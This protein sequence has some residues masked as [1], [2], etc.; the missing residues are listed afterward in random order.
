MH[1]LSVGNIKLPDIY[2]CEDKHEAKEAKHHGLPYVLRPKHMNDNELIAILLWQTLKKKFPHINWYKVLHLPHSKMST[3]IICVPGGEAKANGDTGDSRTADIATSKRTFSGGK[4]IGEDDYCERKL[5]EYIGDESAH[6]NI[7]QLQAL[8][9]LPSF[10]SNIADSIRRNLYG[11]NWSEGY[12]KKLGV[13]IGNFDAAY[14]RRNLMILDI[15]GSIPRGI[16]ATMLTLIDTLRTQANADL[17][18]TGS[19]SLWY[20]AGTE[21]PSPQEI[22]NKCGYGNEAV[23]FNNIL[24]EHVKGRE[25]G[26]VICFGDHDTPR[27]FSGYQ[28]SRPAMEGTKVG[29][30]WSYHTTSNHA[31][32]GYAE[33]VKD[34]VPDVEEEI[35]TSWCSIM[36]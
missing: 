19:I 14:E 13:P 32:P 30:L 8:N 24:R 18:I 35:D 3:V 26:N 15:S 21:L 29:K 25:F 12:N 2:V 5:M 7:E 10:L 28:S 4:A 22:R 31:T 11:Y 1:K 17:I 9:L 34:A 36:C 27:Y 6:V 33:W 23:Q 20:E 16:S